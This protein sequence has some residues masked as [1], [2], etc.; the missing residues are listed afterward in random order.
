MDFNDRVDQGI[1]FLRTNPACREILRWALVRC[2]SERVE[3]S[4]FEK[5]VASRDE[6]G[7]GCPEPFFI[8]Q[9]LVDA[10]C[11]DAFDIDAEGNVVNAEAMAAQGATDDEIDDAIASYAYRTNEVG[12]AVAEAFAPN[13][14]LSKLIAEH[15]EARPILRETLSFLCAQHTLGE[16]SAHLKTSLAPE[17]AAAYGALADSTVLASKLSDAGVI[18]FSS[19]NWRITAEGRELLFEIEHDKR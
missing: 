18:E 14:R 10:G 4:A 12:R 8:A 5:E 17:E 2:S 19:H 1:E 7:K 16:L 3:L 13:V 11:L 9:W 6:Y 15:P